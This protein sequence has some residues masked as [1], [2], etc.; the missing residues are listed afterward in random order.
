MKTRMIFGATLAAVCGVV[1][2]FAQRPAGPYTADQVAPG[3]AAFQ[4]NCA[5]CHAA[6]L[7]GAEGP[8]LA[9]SNF[10]NQWGDRTAGALINF[11]QSTMPPGGAALPPDTYVNIAAFLLDAN[12]ARPGD[13]ALAADSNVVIRS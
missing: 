10:L 3:R 12:S 7:S 6:N 4:T 8:E 9:G 13:R 1:I 11:M 5:S 2:L